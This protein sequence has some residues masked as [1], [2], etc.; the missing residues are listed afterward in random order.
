M[1]FRSQPV[2]AGPVP[3][4]WG[5][6]GGLVTV[7]DG[8]QEAAADEVDRIGGHQTQLGKLQMIVGEMGLPGGLLGEG[9]KVWMCR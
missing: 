3:D 6:G 1:L 8:H 2:V 7:P 4:I 9:H 5:S